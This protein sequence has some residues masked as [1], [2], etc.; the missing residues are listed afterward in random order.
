ME[1]LRQMVGK[2][3]DRGEVGIRI[4]KETTELLES[5]CYQ[6]LKEIVKIV[7]DDRLPDPECFQK[8]EDI[9]C[10]LEWIG[11]DGGSRHDF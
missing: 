5:K 2:A 11:I 3:L 9:V 6:A 10:A 8:I 7:R 4:S 1:L